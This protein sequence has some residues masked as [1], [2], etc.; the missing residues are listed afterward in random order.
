[1]ELDE[2][3]ERKA[4]IKLRMRNLRVRLR[5]LERESPS[6]L[7]KKYRR[8]QSLV[9]KAQAREM[10]QL[11]EELHRACRIAFLELGG[12]ATPDALHSAI[13]RRGSFSFGTMNEKPVVA[14]I[15]TLTAMAES[16]EATCCP[17]G[18]QPKWSY[19]PKL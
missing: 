15:R 16:G 19:H 11:Q 17:N 3:L 2:L 13:E 14:I 4:R 18:S 5:S 10:R 8:S 1:M 7:R 9:R 6:G 12:T